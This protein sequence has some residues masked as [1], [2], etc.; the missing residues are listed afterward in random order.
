MKIY[1]ILMMIWNLS[2]DLKCKF[3][4]DTFMGI[5][6][7]YEIL[8]ENM[9]PLWEPLYRDLKPLWIFET[10]MEFDLREDLKPL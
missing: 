7:V 4:L 6:D 3:I 10:V 1:E 8:R 2:D 5:R 9:K